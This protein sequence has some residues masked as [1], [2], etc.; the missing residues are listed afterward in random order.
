MLAWIYNQLKKSWSP[1]I[2]QARVRFAANTFSYTPHR[3]GTLCPVYA[4]Y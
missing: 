1:C 4:L 3:A 2:A